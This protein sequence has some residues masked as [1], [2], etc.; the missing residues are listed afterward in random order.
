MKYMLITI[1]LTVFLYGKEVDLR[2][3]NNWCINVDEI[4]SYTL[5]DEYGNLY[6]FSSHELM[7]LPDSIY[8]MLYDKTRVKQLVFKNV[9]FK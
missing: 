2:T 9:D 8:D 5:V 4:Q 1:L 7:T 6:T 3:S